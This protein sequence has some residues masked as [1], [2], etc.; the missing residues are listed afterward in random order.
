MIKKL[1]KYYLERW[2]EFFPGRNLPIQ[3]AFVWKIQP[4]FRTI[5]WVLEGRHPVIVA[6]I[7]YPGFDPAVPR[8][9]FGSLRQIRQK[10]HPTLSATVPVPF[11]LDHINERFVLSMSYLSGT[12]MRDT[13]PA[14]MGVSHWLFFRSIERVLDWHANFQKQMSRQE[15]VI[16]EEI[17]ETRLRPV[18]TDLLPQLP[19]L[20]EQRKFVDWYSSVLSEL[21]GQKV[22][23]VWSHGDFFPGNVLWSGK[24]L[25]VM[26]WADMRWG[27]GPLDDIFFFFC[28]FRLLL[29]DNN[30]LENILKTFSR[31]FIEESGLSH[32]VR[33]RIQDYSR[34]VGVDE[35]LL[36]LFFPFF[37]VKMAR[38]DTA[39]RRR[40]WKMRQFWGE[41]LLYYVQNARSFE[42][43]I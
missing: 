30:S 35:H 6:K 31:V 34:R 25:G 28:G 11:A 41:R 29:R 20:A 8:A 21:E 12:P 36:R 10:L 26:D 17:I 15:A 9:E 32:G 39:P 43:S 5:L 4:T 16:T 13:L 7:F 24:R 2:E 37:L 40:N 33:E 18:I 38:F 14:W 1:E 23:F 3:L 42:W 22:S 27:A 19:K